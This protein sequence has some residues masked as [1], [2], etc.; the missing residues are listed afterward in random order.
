MPTAAWRFEGGTPQPP[1]QVDDLGRGG[2]PRPDAGA[3]HRRGDALGGCERGGPRRGA[4]LQGFG[5]VA[6]VD[7]QHQPRLALS[8]I[9]RCPDEGVVD[10]REVAVAPAPRSGTDHAHRLERH[11]EVVFQDRQQSG[12]LECVV[13]LGHRRSDEQGRPVCSAQ[14]LDCG[15]DDA[16]LVPDSAAGPV[17]GDGRRNGAFGVPISLGPQHRP[18]PGGLAPPG[19]GEQGQSDDGA[20]RGTAVSAGGPTDHGERQDGRTGAQNSEFGHRDLLA[21][22]SKGTIIAP[23][24]AMTARMTPMFRAR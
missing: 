22:D 8:R 7:A 16:V 9:R 23:R 21:S 19:H 10:A 1:V 18:D 6:G 20:D 3:G 4:P 15:D 14:H 17:I 2:D 5:A 13:G 11:P 24:I 12:N